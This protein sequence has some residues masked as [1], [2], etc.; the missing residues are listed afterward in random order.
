MNKSAFL[1]LIQQVANISDQQ[2]EELEKVATTFPYCQTAH[3]LLAKSAYDKGSML[4]TQRMRRASAYATNRQL[5]KRIIYTSPTAA[6]VFDETAVEVQTVAVAPEPEV[7]AATLLPVKEEVVIVNA[8]EEVS[9]ITPD[10]ETSIVAHEEYAEEFSSDM[11]EEPQELAQHYLPHDQLEQVETP[12]PS[13]PE[14]SIE[15]ESRQ[16]E[17]QADVPEA[18]MDLPTDLNF[19]EQPMEKLDSELALLLTI[20]SLSPSFTDL[21]TQK[22][23]VDSE[24]APEHEN[25][26]VSDKLHAFYANTASEAEAPS[27]IEE[28]TGSEL[29]APEEALQADYTSEDS[30]TASSTAETAIENEGPTAHAVIASAP[31]E[32]EVKYVFDEIEQMYAQDVLGYWMASSRMGE[33][34]QLKETEEVTRARPQGFH[35]ELILEYSKTHEILKQE[36]QAQPTLHAQIDLID[37][38]L[39][40]NP[41]LKAMQNIKMKPEPQEDLSLKSSK[42][43]RGLASESL[44]NIFVQQGKTKKAIKIYEQLI[45]KN[46]EKKSYF[47]EQIEKLQ[48][49]S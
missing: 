23:D 41:R 37:H 46:P 22:P 1:Q 9:F 16:E 38:F 36:T 18:N 11:A 45:L 8:L 7:Q 48:N 15:T 3:L 39:K 25:G 49:L 26:T 13:Q 35:P 34:L 31:A 28:I 19:L 32:A 30:F 14:A 6:P 33:A 42:I 29:E 10:D 5:L 4:S 17:V 27:S 12:E 44:A 43:K 24:I 21:L 20:K 40:L 47:A 2:T